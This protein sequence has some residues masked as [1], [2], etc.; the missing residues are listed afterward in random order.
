MAA[1]KSASRISWGRCP[2][3]DRSICS[4]TAR[5][6]TW[7]APFID[8]RST[9]Y[10]VTVPLTS[11]AT[12]SNG[13]RVGLSLGID[14]Q[15]A[16]RAQ[17]AR[18]RRVVR[19][20]REVP[21]VRV[22]H[23]HRRPRIGDVVQSSRRPCAPDRRTRTCACRSCPP[24]AFRLRTLV[25]GA[26]V[27][28]AVVVAGVEERRIARSRRCARSRCRCRTPAMP[29]VVQM[30]N[31]RPPS[32]YSDSYRPSPFASPSVLVTLRRPRFRGVLQRPRRSGTRW[33]P[34]SASSRALP[35][36]SPVQSR[37]SPSLAVT[38]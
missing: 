17:I 14:E 19:I 22:V 24:P 26:A 2:R 36:R 12:T 29:S 5:A 16:F 23:E 9:L 21:I 27:E 15:H 30:E 13:A 34:A 31:E 28:R 3:P 33:G 8:S 35:R 1:W 7:P 25:V 37:A 11:F 4:S 6:G 38:R 18:G 10:S 20:D 32:V